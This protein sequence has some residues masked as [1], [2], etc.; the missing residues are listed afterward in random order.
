MKVLEA[1]DPVICHSVHY[2]ARGISDPRPDF[3]RKRVEETKLIGV[4]LGLKQDG[5]S[6]YLNGFVKSMTVSRAEQMVMN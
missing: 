4:A 5:N 1:I 6:R 2:F 3:G